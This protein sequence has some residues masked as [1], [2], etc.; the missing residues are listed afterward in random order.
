M[1]VVLL[2]KETLI[3]LRW[4]RILSWISWVAAGMTSSFILSPSDSKYS[5]TGGLCADLSGRCFWD[6]VEQTLAMDLSMEKVS[7]QKLLY[8]F[9]DYTRLV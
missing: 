5:R 6:S 9:A 2:R 7:A 3:L 4:Q 1:S 8:L